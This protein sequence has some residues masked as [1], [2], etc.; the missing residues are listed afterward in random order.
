MRTAAWADGVWLSLTQGYRTYKEQEVL[1]R[2]RYTKEVLPG[3]PTKRWNGEVWYQRPKTAMAAVPGTS[4]HGL[5]L[6]VDTAI[7][8]DGDQEFEWP[9]KSLDNKAIAWLLKNA[10]KYG[11]AWELQSEP[12]HLVYVAGDKIP[13]A[14]NQAA[15]SVHAETLSKDLLDAMELK[16]RKGSGKTKEE[17]AAVVWLQTFLNKADLKVL[18]DGDFGPKT[19]EAVKAFQRKNIDKVGIVDG[20]VSNKTWEALTR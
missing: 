9:P 18:V 12:W 20:V 6:A 19:E 5:A 11:F 2:S 13:P 16:L 17:K 10:N 1:F 14:V 4:N 7:D 8:K 15:T 3:Q